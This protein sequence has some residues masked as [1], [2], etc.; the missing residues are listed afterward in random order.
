MH[1]LYSKMLAAVMA[2]A[3]P[4]AASAAAD[5][6]DN[7]V[8][9]SILSAEN[10]TCKVVAPDEGDYTGDVV[11]ASAVTK[12]G[13]E[14]TV[15][16]IG[17]MA[18]A[19]DQEMT[20][21]TYPPTLT[22]VGYSAFRSCRGLTAVYISD[23]KAW[24]NIDMTD[25]EGQ[26]LFYAHNLYLNGELLKDVVVPEGVTEIK[27]YAFQD[28][29]SIE[30]LVIPEG[31]TSMGRSAFNLCTSLKSVTLP[32]SLPEIS[33]SAFNSNYS[34][35]SIVIPEGVTTLDGAAF[36][37]CTHLKNVSL[38]QSLKKID[39]EAFREC[40]SLEEIVIPR[41][42][43]FIGTYCF[44]KCV[45]LKKVV[46]ES[47]ALEKAGSLDSPIFNECNALKTV[48]YGSG[49][50]NVPEYMLHN[51]V[52]HPAVETVLP[53][54]TDIRCNSVAPPTA[55]PSLFNCVDTDAARLTVPD[56]SAEHY[57]GH[58]VWGQI[59]L[60][61]NSVRKVDA[62]GAAFTVAG[63]AVSFNVDAT[64]YS[65][66]GI[67]RNANGGQTL[68]LTPGIYLIKAGDLV[69]KIAIR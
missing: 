6:V 53:A 25:P 8:Y 26:P 55:A 21:V 40:Y 29:Q 56:E 10:H 62:A 58:S 52:G 43:T 48:E 49:V 65:A 4:V 42:V 17:S 68:T 66:T 51:M 3:T 16:E 23:L 15:T 12:D 47:E 22:K 30:T 38:P 14:Y 9:Y 69:S 44:E 60:A 41:N 57:R 45:S 35:E 59:S 33:S 63:R 39:W 19:F 67:F 37:T 20:S 31:V 2:V 61:S 13:V 46:I 54:L 1:K 36:I 34:L 11:I 7:G 50:T 5:I 27:K 18:F 32:S 64:V 28:C 24:F